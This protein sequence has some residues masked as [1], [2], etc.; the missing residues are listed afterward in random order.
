MQGRPGIVNHG[1]GDLADLAMETRPEQVLSEIERLHMR[2]I[3][4]R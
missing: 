4:K 2:E 1:K 3:S